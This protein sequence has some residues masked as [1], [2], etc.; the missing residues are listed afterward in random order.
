MLNRTTAIL[1]KP[2]VGTTVKA[3]LDLACLGM[4]RDLTALDSDIKFVV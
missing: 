3:I 1:A 2:T 4:T